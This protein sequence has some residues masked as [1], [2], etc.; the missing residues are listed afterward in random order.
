MCSQHHGRVSSTANEIFR[1]NLVRNSITSLNID[2]NETVI[3]L[4][5]PEAYFSSHSGPETDQI[6]QAI[7]PAYRKGFRTIFLIGAAL[8]A[9]AFVVAFF[10]MPQIDLDRPDDQKLKD[11]GKRWKEASKAQH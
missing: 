1:N 10:L 9:V 5:S 7:I 11:E 2:P 6:Q 8:A 4:K 3:I